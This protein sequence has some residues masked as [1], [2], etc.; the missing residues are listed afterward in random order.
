[1]TQN[2]YSR[3][4]RAPFPR[5]LAARIALKASIMADRFEDQAIRSMVGDAQ[6]AL[7]RGVREDVIATEMA[8][9]SP[10]NRKL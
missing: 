3:P 7:D 5:T 6:H 9:P 8:L 1:M 2:D 4:K 10:A